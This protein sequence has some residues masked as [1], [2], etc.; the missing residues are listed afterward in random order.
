MQRR[1]AL[2]LLAMGGLLPAS[3]SLTTLTTA[4]AAGAR[5]TGRRLILVE[6][7]GAND[8]LNTLVPLMHDQYQ[9][10]RPRVSLQRGD[11]VSLENDFFLHEALTPLLKHWQQ[12]NLAWV[13]GL[14]YPT[15]NRSH[16]KSAAIWETG[17]DGSSERRNGWITHDLEHRLKLPPVDPH[18]ISLVDDIALFTSDSGRWLSLSHPEQLTAV[19]VASAPT[20]DPK[21]ASL[22]FVANQMQG[23]NDSLNSM[24]KKLENLGDV[25]KIAGGEL[26]RQLQQVVKLIRSG[27][28]TPVYR[29]RLGGFDTHANQRGRH[30]RLMTMLGRALASFSNLLIRDGEWNNTLI[31]TYSEFGRRVAENRSGG[32]DHGTAAPHLLLGGGVQGGLF[33]EHPDLDTLVDGDM[34]YTTDYRSLYQQVLNGWFGI[35]RNEFAEFSSSALQPLIKL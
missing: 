24:S 9:K 29:V 31:M 23:L 32:T 1:N 10:L 5:D 7:S 19:S 33:G 25:R 8:G 11:V 14:G 12:G 17:S 18:G 26:G 27:I 30:D 21:L 4:V 34:Q 16:F 35:P 20:T 15:P 3:G 22:A 6:L 2:K 13:Q 28:D